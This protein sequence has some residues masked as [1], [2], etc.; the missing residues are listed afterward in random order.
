MSKASDKKL[1]SNSN[2][3]SDSSVIRQSQEALPL[4]P[5]EE[6]LEKLIEKVCKKLVVTLENKIDQKFE[7]LNQKI[8][9]M[10]EN[11]S[12]V[13]RRIQDNEY[14]VQSLNAI[15]DQL[16]RKNSLRISGVPEHDKED[17]LE[18]TLAFLNKHLNISCSQS[19][20]DDVFR[21]GTVK[22]K[23]GFR[24]ILVRF[25]TTMMRNKV[26]QAKKLL[27]NM[28][29]SIFE[30]LSKSNYELF[31][32][33]QRKHGRKNVWTMGGKL[34]IKENEAK[35]LVNTIKDL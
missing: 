10:G 32:L 16:G 2:S 34:F 25:V 15:V 21:I 5:S 35:R 22:T 27:K 23:T 33:A 8:L 7:D 3:L 31:Q 26:Y 17:I 28:G 18:T 9:R 4:V 1:R 12:K 30:D 24:T 14:E 19:D 11:V 20:I 29:I 13:E 6:F